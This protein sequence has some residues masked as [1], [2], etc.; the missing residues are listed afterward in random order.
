M[1]KELKCTKFFF[2]E[3]RITRVLELKELYPDLEIFQ[4]PS[5]KLMLA[6]EGGVTPYHYVKTYDEVEDETMCIIHSS[7]TTGEF[8]DAI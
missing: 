4:V 8:G 2:P 6:D 1:L 7:G 5:V 3:E